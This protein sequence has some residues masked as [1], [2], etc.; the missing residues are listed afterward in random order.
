MQ[1]EAESVVQPNTLNIEALLNEYDPY[2]RQQA[3]RHMLNARNRFAPETLDMEIDELAQKIRI[4]IWGAWQKQDISNPKGYIGRI[5]QNEFISMMRQHRPINQLPLDEEGELY[6]GDV[7]GTISQEGQDPADEVEQ[8][9]TCRYYLQGTVEAIVALP[10]Q[11]RQAMLYTLKVKVDDVWAFKRECRTH[12]I[13]VEALRPPTSG[14]ELQ[15]MRSSATI[16]RKKLRQRLNNV[17]TPTLQKRFL[18]LDIPMS[19]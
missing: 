10:Q 14:K 9:D 7:V 6:Q 1:I 5:A 18:P 19:R 11:Q 17:Y 8:S 3:R 4:K 12:N 16:A 2:I 13:D 15:T